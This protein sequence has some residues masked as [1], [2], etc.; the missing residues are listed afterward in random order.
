IGSLIE[1]LE[2]KNASLKT[3]LNGRAYCGAEEG[4]I[5]ANQSARSSSAAQHA[6]GF[7]VITSRYASCRK[8]LHQGSKKTFQGEFGH[9]LFDE[10]RIEHRPV[11][12]YQISFL[13][14]GAMK[15]SDIAVANKDFR[16]GAD[17]RVI[18]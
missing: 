6:N 4:Q 2:E 9:I 7:Y 5:A 10:I 1:I 12:R 15:G 8:R 3:R 13:E 17:N 18:Q 16:I 14:K 11:K